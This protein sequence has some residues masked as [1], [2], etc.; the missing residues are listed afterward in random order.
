MSDT[1]DLIAALKTLSKCLEKFNQK[2]ASFFEE[3]AKRVVDGSSQI[4]SIVNGL[5][6]AITAIEL[7]QTLKA[8]V[9]KLTESLKKPINPIKV[10]DAVNE[11]KATLD[12]FVAAG[13]GAA[14]GGA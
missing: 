8:T 3:H 11:G 5:N 6:K 12:K 13:S 2:A 10:I 14:I 9:Q 1:K 7:A 4:T